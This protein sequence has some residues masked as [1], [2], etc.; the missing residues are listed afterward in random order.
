MAI[1]L[2]VDSVPLSERPTCVQGCQGNSDIRRVSDM[3]KILMI[4]WISLFSFSACKAKRSDSFQQIAF[5]SYLVNESECRNYAAEYSTDLTAYSCSFDRNKNSFTCNVNS[6]PKTGAYK[7]AESIVERKYDSAA[8]FVDERQYVKL[9]R[10]KQHTC[11]GTCI[12]QCFSEIIGLCSLQYSITNTFDSQKRLLVSDNQLGKA[13]YSNWDFA[14]RPISGSSY[15]SYSGVDVFSQNFSVSYNDTDRTYF[16]N[17]KYPSGKYDSNMN[18][19]EDYAFSSSGLIAQKYT[20]KST[21]KVCK[22]F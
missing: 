20:I 18:L 13:K 12:I 17:S 7:N 1:M 21:K 14:G 11:T 9:T 4:F 22:L 3:K 2:H 10:Y 5:F 16:E 19:I 6:P 8:D 15:T